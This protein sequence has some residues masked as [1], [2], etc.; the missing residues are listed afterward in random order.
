MFRI[1]LLK[2]S[3][4]RGTW[5]WVWVCVGF[6]LGRVWVKYE[7]ELVEILM[8]FLNLF[9]PS[10]NMYEPFIPG[11]AIRELVM[12]WQLNHTM[13]LKVK[14]NCKIHSCGLGLYGKPL[15]VLIMKI[16]KI[17]M[18]GMVD[19]DVYY[20]WW[21]RSF[22]VVVTQQMNPTERGL[23][24]KKIEREWGKEMERAEKG[25]TEKER[26]CWERR[27]VGA[28]PLTETLS[29]CWPQLKEGCN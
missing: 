17:V 14:P 27:R 12:F 5:R 29:W 22:H 20:R 26:E 24:R 7:D 8:G 10:S 25:W 28:F 16:K 9:L 15:V 4:L 1:L 18:K 11:S 13:K 6:L 21:W 23:E 2:W 19:D 3:G